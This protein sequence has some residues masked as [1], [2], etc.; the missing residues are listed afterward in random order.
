MPTPA[1]NE[2]QLLTKSLRGETF[3]TRLTSGF[4]L[5]SSSDWVLEFT[6][7]NGQET[8]AAWTTGSAHTAHV[9]FMS[10]W[11]QLNLTSTP[12]YVNPSTVPEPGTIPLLLMAGGLFSLV[13]RR[14]V[15]WRVCFWGNQAV[16]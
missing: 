2:L 1:Y 15:W 16:S 6:A 8:L 9:Y 11:T 3:S 4:G 13:Y 14:R 10:R 5:N 12:F 7:P